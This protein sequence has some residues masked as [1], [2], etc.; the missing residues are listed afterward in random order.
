[1]DSETIDKIS[2]GD[3]YLLKQI[4]KCKFTKNICL[5]LVSK[6]EIKK[7]EYK[8]I[9]DVNSYSSDFKDFCIYYMNKLTDIDDCISYL[10]KIT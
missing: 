4:P 5:Q 1:M 6:M 10:K 2:E 7:L 3:I 8:K 9:L